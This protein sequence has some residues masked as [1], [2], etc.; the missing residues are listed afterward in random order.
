M[1]SKK[2]SNFW[3]NIL[4]WNILPIPPNNDQNSFE[5]TFISVW[6]NQMEKNSKI[7]WKMARKNLSKQMAFLMICSKIKSAPKMQNGCTQNRG[8]VKSIWQNS[9]F[10][11]SF[12]GFEWFF[13]YMSHKTFFCMNCSVWA[14]LS[15]FDCVC[16]VWI[17]RFSHI[18]TI[19]LILI[20]IVRMHIGSLCFLKMRGRVNLL[21]SLER[22]VVARYVC[23]D[24]TFIRLW[25][26][27]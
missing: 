10:W 19:I 20:L 13:L 4:E 1:C 27:D 14:E 11:V 6:S 25:C 21:S 22:M 24:G 2:I 8:W 9:G 7:S 16:A 26:V 5:N 23:H 3:L 15:W 12:N 18:V 17:E